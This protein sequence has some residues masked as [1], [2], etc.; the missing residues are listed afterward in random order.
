MRAVLNTWLRRWAEAS[1][2]T[3]MH[4]AQEKVIRQQNISERLLAES[5]RQAHANKQKI[6]NL[7]R[8]QKRSVSHS[9]KLIKALRDRMSP[10][11][12]LAVTEHVRAME[13]RELNK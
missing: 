6:E 7:K 12:F 4:Q 11:L 3:E 2:R 9:E 1:L 10:D 5:Q 13:S 8:N